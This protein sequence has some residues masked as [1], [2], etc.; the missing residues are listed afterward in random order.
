M[1]SDSE[2]EEFEDKIRLSFARIKKDMQE[3]RSELS[4]VSEENLQLKLR[5][6]ETETELRLKK[7]TQEDDLSTVS[8]VETKGSQKLRLN[9]SP[10][11]IKG[12]QSLRQ[13]KSKT[14]RVSMV[15]LRRTETML[16]PFEQEFLKKLN[17]NKKQVIQNYILSALH[18][19]ELTPWEL[20]EQ[21]VDKAKYCSKASFYRYLKELIS[22]GLVKETTKKGVAVLS[23]II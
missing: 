22:L 17:K 3:L 1:V 18:E 8:P 19:K 10:R 11:E 4:K 20:K 15:P 21:V 12:S 2:F 9:Q 13:H 7:H 6:S 5:V 23:V 14:D 16:N